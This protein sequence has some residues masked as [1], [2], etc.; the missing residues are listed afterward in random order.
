MYLELMDKLVK[1]KM[2][3]PK[4]DSLAQLY[5]KQN[6]LQDSNGQALQPLDIKDSAI[7]AIFYQ[8]LIQRDLNWLAQYWQR[9]IFSGGSQPPAQLSIKDMIEKVKSN[10]SVLGYLPVKSLYR[11][12]KIPADQIRV[13]KVIEVKKAK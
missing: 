10:P 5:L 2:K 6:L 3:V 4:K 9:Q 7:R 12:A 13:L 8:Y 1:N 11:P